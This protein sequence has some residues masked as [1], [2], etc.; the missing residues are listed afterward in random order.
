M[1]K[2]KRLDLGDCVVV[3]PRTGT[4]EEPHLA[5]AERRRMECVSCGHTVSLEMYLKVPEV[6]DEQ[7]PQCG[8]AAKDYW[9][10]R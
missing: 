3:P 7:C 10:V 1:Y 9:K 4:D 8:V 2:L 6:Y 5:G